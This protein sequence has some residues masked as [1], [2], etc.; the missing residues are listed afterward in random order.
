MNFAA[1]YDKLS[2]SS[3]TKSKSFF[4]NKVIIFKIYFL[5]LKFKNLNLKFKNLNL[6]FKNLNLNR[7]QLEWRESRVTQCLKKVNLF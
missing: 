6:K 4:S 5:N 7:I 3:V 1:C 2:R